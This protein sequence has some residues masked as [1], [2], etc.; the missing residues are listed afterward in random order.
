MTSKPDSLPRFAWPD[1]RGSAAAFTFDLDAES[2]WIA[3]DPA[4]AQRPGLL[5]QGVY[6]PRV[7]VPLILDL[8]DRHGIRATFFVP[9]VVAEGYPEAVEPIVAA[10]HE[11]GLHG[12]THDAPDRLSPEAEQE[13]LDRAYE[14]L[15]PLADVRGYRSPSWE[16]SP[17]TLDLLEKKGLL[18]A[19][20][21]MDDLKPYRHPGRRLIELPVQ[22]ILDD[23]PHFAWWVAMPQRSIRSAAEV[24]QIWREELE[25]MRKLGGS[26]VLTMHP[27]VI[28]RPGRLDMLDRFFELVRTY[29]DVWIAPCAELAAHADAV[30]PRS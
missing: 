8:L 6:G 24:E 19:S 15:S 2:G 27:Q 30:L 26:F 18:Y 13:Q 23:V 20:Q 21:M 7:A 29:E 16:V 10:G 14:I 3:M 5:S 28:G 9:G 1:G 11:L 25:G 4:N 17:R 22:W 12:Y